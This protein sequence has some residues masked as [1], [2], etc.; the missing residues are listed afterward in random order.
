MANTHTRTS[1]SCQLVDQRWNLTTG[2]YDAAPLPSKDIQEKKEGHV[3]LHYHPHNPHTH[4]ALGHSCSARTHSVSLSA[5]SFL[6]TS[7]VRRNSGIASLHLSSAN[8]SAIFHLRFF[9]HF[10]PHCF[11][12]GTPRGAVFEQVFLGLL[13]PVTPPA[14]RSLIHF[15]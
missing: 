12:L 13:G 10:G 5:G 14:F 7:V 3:S 4:S 9:S 15:I 8:S 11:L 2:Q 1:L 6:P